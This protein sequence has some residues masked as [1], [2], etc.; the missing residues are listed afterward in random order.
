M[1][2]VKLVLGDVASILVSRVLVFWHFPYR[3]DH[4][5][6]VVNV[7][8]SADPAVVVFSALEVGVRSSIPDPSDEYNVC[9]V[10]G[11]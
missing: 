9:F 5:L 7:D 3:A 1:L 11:L 8:E 6:S 4:D 2:V 10:L